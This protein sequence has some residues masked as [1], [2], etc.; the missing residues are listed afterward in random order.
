VGRIHQF[1]EH[2]RGEGLGSMVISAIQSWVFPHHL[3]SPSQP[4]R[5][6]LCVPGRVLRPVLYLGPTIETVPR[7]E[8]RVV[9]SEH[10]K[11]R[12]GNPLAHLIFNFSEEDCR[13]LDLTR[14][15]ILKLW[16]QLGVGKVREAEVTFSRHHIGT[17]RMGDNPKTS[18]TDRTLRVH[19]C[20]N[21]YLGGCETFV[22]GAAV[23]PVLTIVALAHRLADEL[24][25][26]LRHGHWDSNRTPTKLSAMGERNGCFHAAG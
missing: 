14:R 23:P 5:D 19:E 25:T 6:I 18:V 2:L 4:L 8:N 9:L 7:D 10:T 21:L 13:T 22:T 3:M 17:C 16:K 11:D 24:A 20:P 26:R 15:L 1:Y 12:F